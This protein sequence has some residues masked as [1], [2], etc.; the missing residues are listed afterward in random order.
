MF[1]MPDYKKILPHVVAVIVFIALSYAYF[2]PLLEGKRLEQHD[3]KTFKGG[4][5]EIID[6]REAT[7]EEALWT[8]RMFAGMP[9]YMISVKYKGNLLQ[10]VNRALQLGQ[11]PGSQL[12]LL[13][14]GAYILFVSLRVN[15][16]LSIAGAIALAFSSYNFII[17]FA[18][19]NTKVIAIA[20]AAP[21]LGGIFLTY[22]GKRILGA[23]L[24][25]IFLSLQILANHPQITYYTLIIVLFFGLSELYFSIKE[26]QLKDLLV[27]T[28]LLVAVVAFSVLSN[29]SRLSTTMEYEGYSM[30]SASEL[31]EDESDK[32][33]GLTL[34]YATMWSYGVNET[35]T[36]LIPGFK[37][38]SS[39]YNIGRNS[40]TYDALA[41]LDRNFARNFVQNANMYW[42][43]QQSTSGPVYVGAVVVF[44]FVLGL[45]ILE[46]RVKWWMLAAAILGIMLSW[47]KN[48]M[49][50][51]EFFMHYV[52]GYSKFRTVSMTMV[53]PQIVMPILA[54]LTLKKVIAEDVDKSR[55]MY[56]LKWSAGIV[57]G[58]SLLFLVIPS[59]AGN[60]SSEYDMRTIAAMSGNN[61]QVRQMLTDS[62]IPALEADRQSMLRTDAFRSLVFILLSGGLIYLYRIRGQK[63]NI[64]LVIGLFALL[65]LFDMWPVNKRFLNDGNFVS[66]SKVEQPFTATAADQA[67]LRSTGLNERV[68]N[69][70]TSPFQD[71]STSYF[72]QSIGGYHGAKMR[73]YQD[74]INTRLMDEMTMLIGALQSQDMGTIDT[75]LSN[76]NILNMLNTKYFI[77]N[78]NGNPLTNPSAMGNAWFVNDFRIAQN[79]DEELETLTNLELDSEA[80][81]DKKFSGQLSAETYPGSISDRIVLT[82]YLPNRLTYSSVSSTKR[83]AVFS[84]IYY[85]EGWTATIDGEPADHIRVNYLLR[86]MEIPAGEHTI[87][88]EFRPASYFTGEKISYAGSVLLILFFL[89]AVFLEIKKKNSINT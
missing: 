42:G 35:F 24:T 2:S 45:F 77:I 46:G 7:G 31:T 18:G 79:A 86:G 14:L 57:G 66:K 89:G 15:P 23:A 88:F 52:P 64:N 59:L 81:L 37:G 87:V 28:G 49:G 71:A 12:F 17:L 48:F 19:H 16:W 62:L 78:P 43:S 41:K 63:M 3:F 85:P 72:H 51:T 75:T 1:K 50:L 4:A 73:R 20:Y 44:L 47:G 36:L 25:G 74:L 69:L 80:V 10:H 54:I 33:G 55:L 27:S 61:Q 32:T 30:R 26:K 38:G 22:R 13:L 39:A 6:Y 84:E 34:S 67:I 29:Y 8:N 83:L 60:F 53:I 11:R 70:T 76:S 82:D 21:V 58:L 9:A 56:G 68:L 5:K 40:E 65:F